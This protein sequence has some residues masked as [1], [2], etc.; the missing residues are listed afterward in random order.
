MSPLVRDGDMLLVHPVEPGT[1]RVGDIVLCT[2]HPGRVV[3]HRLIR[4]LDGPGGTRY[5]VQGD[6]LPSPDGLL[7]ETHI[8]G[9]LA[10][11]DRAGTRIDVEQPVWRMLSRLAVLRSRQNVGRGPRLRAVRSLLKRLPVVSR[12]LG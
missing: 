8:Y 7:P 5:V 9:R 3:V 12:Y 4:G 10:A 2:T 1:L 6:Q 11:I